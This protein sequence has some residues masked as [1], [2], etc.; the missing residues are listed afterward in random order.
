VFGAAS[1]VTS[2]VGKAAAFLSADDQFIASTAK[3]Q[4]KEIKHVG[5][6]VARGAKQLGMGLFRGLTG[7]VT[8]PLKGAEKGGAKGFFKGVGKGLLGVVAKPVR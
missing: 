5:D 3:E 1:S 2:S 7:L 4:R 8:D 6:G